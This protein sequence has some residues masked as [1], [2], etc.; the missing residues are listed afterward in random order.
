M[1]KTP[2]AP[3]NLKTVLNSTL[4]NTKTIWEAKLSIAQNQ[5]TVAQTRPILN[6]VQ[7]NTQPNQTKSRTKVE[8][9]WTTT[10]PWQKPSQTKY[11]I[12]S[13]KARILH[14]GT[15]YELNPASIAFVQLTLPFQIFQGI[16]D[17]VNDNSLHHMQCCKVSNAHTNA[18]CSLSYVEQLKRQPH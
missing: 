5:P 15:C 17:N 18:Q 13:P 8:T 4:K 14:K 2:K 12:L 7:T 1:L 10:E 11:K 3:S 6:K 16:M 9:I